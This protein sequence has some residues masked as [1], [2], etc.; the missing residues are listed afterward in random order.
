MKQ[1]IG[2]FDQYLRISAGL[3]MLG[4]G[5]RRNSLIMMMLGSMKVAE[6]IT[7]WCPM[8]H[9]LGFSTTEKDLAQEINPQD[10]LENIVES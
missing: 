7:R 1:N 10:I 2:R 3:T 8:L 9:M 5:I 4:M 6:G